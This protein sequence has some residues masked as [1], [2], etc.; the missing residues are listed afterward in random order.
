MLGILWIIQHVGVFH[1]PDRFLRENLLDTGKCLERCKGLR[2]HKQVRRWLRA[3]QPQWN[4]KT[5]RME[6]PERLDSPVWQLAPVYPDLQRQVLGAAHS[7][8]L[9]QVWRH[10]AGKTD[11]KLLNVSPQISV[12]KLFDRATTGSKLWHRWWIECFG[13]LAHRR[14]KISWD[15]QKTCASV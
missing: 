8:F 10:T 9:P 1:L 2:S 15:M 12:G 6:T 14:L 13:D 3:T 11:N 5:G 7:M 4:N